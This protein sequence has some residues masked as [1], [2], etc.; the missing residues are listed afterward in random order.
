[1]SLAGYPMSRASVAK[2]AFAGYR[3][4]FAG[5]RIQYTHDD[6]FRQLLMSC[7]FMA[8]T[9]LLATCCVLRCAMSREVSQRLTRDVSRR[10][11]MSRDVSRSLF[12]QLSYRCLARRSPVPVE[13]AGDQT[14]TYSSTRR[15]DGYLFLTS[16]DDG[17]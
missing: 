6:R 3:I 4:H 12:S 2:T 14:T 8:K 15:R 7:A 11:A 5:C 1:M 9:A 13:P 10:L 17:V 16:C